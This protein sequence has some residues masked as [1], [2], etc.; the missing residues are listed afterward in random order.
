MM[1]KDNVSLRNNLWSQLI[2]VQ[3]NIKINSTK[4]ISAVQ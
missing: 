1:K 4:L 3:H 2:S